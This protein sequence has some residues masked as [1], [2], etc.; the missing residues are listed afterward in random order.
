[1]TI[2]ERNQL[3]E[4][5]I[6]LAPFAANKFRSIMPYAEIDELIAIAELAMVE[7]TDKYNGMH[8]YTTF[9]MSCVKNAFLKERKAR[10]CKCRG[11]GM[12]YPISLDEY[13]SKINDDT[14]SRHDVVGGLYDDDDA[15][16]DIDRKRIV[17]QMTKRLNA[18]EL[19]AITKHCIEDR[20]Y[21]EIAD[22][23][24]VKWQRVQQIVKQGLEKMARA[25]YRN[26]E[27]A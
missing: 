8:L 5:N 1:M 23:Y 13:V 6:K 25:G 2:E 20:P 26:S 10:M 19:D 14:L 17:R 18:Q 12:P 16:E 7:A 21:R 3:I 24:G 11:G 27:Y 22:E 15:A 9:V 4:D